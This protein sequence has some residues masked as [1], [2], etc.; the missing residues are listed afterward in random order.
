MRAFFRR[1]FGELGGVYEPVIIKKE[2]QIT[3]W[4]RWEIQFTTIPFST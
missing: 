1:L 4:L 3:E 2:A